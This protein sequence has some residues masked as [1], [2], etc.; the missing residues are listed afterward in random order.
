MAYKPTQQF[1]GSGG[2]A[3]SDDLTQSCRVGGVNIRSGTYVDSIE[4]VYIKPGGSTY[5]GGKHGGNGGSGA[6]FKLVDGESIVRVDVRAGTYVDQLKFT[7]NLGNVYG[8]Y[9]GNGGTAS[10]IT[11]QIGGIFGRSGSL[12]DNIGFFNA[13]TCP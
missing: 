11:G 13:A 10:A 5:S 4:F 6:S 9:A 12:L 1:G 3:F 7:T 2:N 8:P